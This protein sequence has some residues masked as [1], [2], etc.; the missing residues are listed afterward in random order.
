MTAPRIDTRDGHRVNP[1]RGYVRPGYRAP[2]PDTWVQPRKRRPP[3]RDWRGLR[4]QTWSEL[5]AVGWALFAIASGLVMLTAGVL[6]FVAVAGHLA[7][8]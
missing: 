6:V 5:Q 7:W 8:R 4:M 2:D 1:A 3:R